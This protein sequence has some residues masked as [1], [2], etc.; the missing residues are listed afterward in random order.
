ML[1]SCRNIHH[2]RRNYSEGNSLNVLEELYHSEN[3]DSCYNDTTTLGQTGRE[4]AWHSSL[5]GLK[6][7]PHRY[8]CKIFSDSG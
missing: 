5:H 2:C 8:F 4:F 7:P 6:V 1:F 3:L